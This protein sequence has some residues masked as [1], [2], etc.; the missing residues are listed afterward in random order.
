[1]RAGA[2]STGFVFVVLV[3]LL[4]RPIAAQS[5][6]A[7]TATVTQVVNAFHAAMKSGN[8]IE[9]MRLIAADAQL[10][11]SGAIETR[12]EFEKNHLP[13]DFQFEKA[14]P[15]KRGPSRVT[16]VGDAAWAVTTTEYKGTSQG[17]PLD[18]VGVELM[19]LSRDPAGWRI[20]AVHWSG[21]SRV[22]VP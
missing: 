20:R 14:I 22:P 7:A 9:V 17:Q 3:G 10:L 21:R 15:A 8:A 18:M 4:G 19:V 2:R 11:E 12:A 16:V 13:A 6:S 5:Q 1:M